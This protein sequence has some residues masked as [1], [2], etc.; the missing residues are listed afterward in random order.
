MRGLENEVRELKDLLDEKDE[1][2]DMLTRIHSGSSQ[3]LQIPTARRPSSTSIGSS[4]TK[5]ETLLGEDDTFRV[6]QSPHLSTGVR[7]GAD[8]YFCGTSSSRTFIES[9]KQKVKESGRPTAEIDTDALLASKFRKESPPTPSD[10]P[11]VVWKAPPRLVSDQLVNIF[12]QEWAPLFPVLHRPTFLALYEK[13]VA[14]A[15][16]VTDKTATAQLNLVF[17]IAALSNGSRATS[18]LESFEDQWKA[19][20]DAI[21]NENT[22]ATLQALIL[23]Q[24]Y[25]VQKGDLTRL[26]TYKGLSMTL[27]AR[28]GL[29]QSQKRFALGTLTSE[30]RKKVFWTLYTVDSFTAVTLGLPK[31][32]KDDDVHCEYPVDADD[33]YVTERGFQ[34][35]LPGESTKLSSALALFRAARILSKVL[36][37]VFPAKASYDLSMKTLAGLS[38]ELDAWT[39]SLAPHLRLQF[40]QDKPSTGTVTSRSPLLSL[41]YHYIRALIHRPAVCASAGSRF[42]SSMMTLAGSCKHIVQLV[43]LLEERG[44]SFA[45]CMNRDELLVTS[46]FGLLFQGL[47][48]DAASKILRDNHKVVLRIMDMLDKSK[49]PCASDFSKV[50]RTFLPAEPAASTHKPTPQSSKRV[51]ATQKE[52]PSLSRHNSD[53]AAPITINP[54][55]SLPASTRKHLRAIAS[56]FSVSGNSKPP[57]LDVSP[58]Q[59]RATVHNISLHPT[60]SQPSLAYQTSSVSRSEPSRSPNNRPASVHIRPSAPPAVQPIT[61]LRDIQPPPPRTQ[62]QQQ[63][64]HQ[65]KPTKPSK[66]PNL[67]YLSFDTSPAVSNTA[68]VPIK[69]EPSPTDW[70]KLLGSLDNGQTNIYDACYGGQPV[71]ALIDTPHG[72]MASMTSAATAVAGGGGAGSATIWDADFWALCQSD[73]KTSSAS[74]EGLTSGGPD[75]LFSFSSD[76]EGVEKAGSGGDGFTTS[77][78]TGGGVDWMAGSGA[79]NAA[80]ELGLFKGICMPAD[81]VGGAADFESAWEGA[82]GY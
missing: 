8:S 38:D 34:P 80:E 61:L 79:V 57:Q 50:A 65:H 64:R 73:T 69:S 9:F 58:E 54:I 40:V 18:D 22:M 67:D 25:C 49:A 71:E 41:T 13:Y 24:I 4:S 26:L 66:L 45:F 39:T 59:R 32:L 11:P 76:E 5:P 7:D 37:E 72:G 46:G 19:T 43:Q 70:E 75:S 82:Y 77:G 55:A 51:L 78:A 35:T 1:K 6:Q 33:E 23:A 44:M 48:L 29:H 10:S 27:S 16:A 36:E 53:P 74:T 52:T 62:H 28:L 81:L 2:I 56:R 63:Q 60:Q 21:L 42:S 30:T 68:S 3:S 12:F 20:I 15:E 14:D 17:G 31:Q 47:G